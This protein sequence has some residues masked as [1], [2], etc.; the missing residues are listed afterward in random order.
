MASQTF[1][2][3]YVVTA[4]AGTPTVTVA[5]PSGP[6][7]FQIT[8]RVDDAD[9]INGSTTFGNLVDF[10]SGGAPIALSFVALTDA[11][12][13]ILFA[14]SQSILYS[15]DP[16]LGPTVDLTSGP[17][18]FLYCFASDTQ[19]ATEAGETAVEVLKIGDTVQTADGRTVAVKWIGRQTLGKWHHAP[20]MQPV[21]IQAGALGNGLPHSDLTVTAD[22]GMVIDGYV[23]NASA[24]VNGHSIDWVPMAEL[25]DR[26]TVYHIET[27]A[28]DVILANG[29]PAETFIDYRDRRAFDNFDEYLALYGC[30]RLIPE[31]AQ[32]RISSAR[33][34]PPALRQRFGVGPATD[35]AFTSQPA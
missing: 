8:E 20:H 30:E 7:A 18:I 9:G 29:A 33:A 25:E 6:A 24:L 23:I 28:H 4:G 2:Y 21:R 35:L 32:P 27:E 19:I 12:D 1:Q 3:A 15:N 34:L 10:D 26:F 31:M 16:S 22:H 5:A 11:G 17:T 14:G 13:P